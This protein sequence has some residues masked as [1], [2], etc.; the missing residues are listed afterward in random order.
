MHGP[1]QQEICD[2]LHQNLWF[3]TGSLAECL[4]RERGLR[5][6]VPSG[7]TS[8]PMAHAMRDQWAA[9]SCRRKAGLPQTDRCPTACRR[10]LAAFVGRLF[11]A[12]HG[13]RSHARSLPQHRRPYAD[14]IAEQVPLGLQLLPNILGL[15]Q[16]G[17]AQSH[18]RSRERSE[19][20]R[21]LKLSE[22]HPGRADAVLAASDL[23][24]PV[25]GSINAFLVNT[26]DS[27]Y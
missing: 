21:P 19:G 25:D 27:S 23:A 8:A 22:S 2:F 9:F 7:E 24:A 3:L 1:C 26:G 16:N 4:S 17:D 20:A 5:N 11:R 10:L 13:H 12:A 6:N 18:G 14:F 15:I